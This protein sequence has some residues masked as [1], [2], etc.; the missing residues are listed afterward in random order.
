M[1]RLPASPAEPRHTRGGAGGVGRGQWV[2][3][4]LRVVVDTVSYADAD[5]KIYGKVKA[6][7]RG[8][9][10]EASV[11]RLAE[12][13]GLSVS[14]VEKA[15]TRL[16]RPAPTD[17]IAELTRRQRSHR[18]TGKGLTN[19]RDTR[20]LDADERY[21][22][23][24]VRAADTLRGTLHRLY[25]L[26]R[27]TTFVEHR[28]LTLAEIGEALRH[29]GGKH[30]VGEALHEGTAARLL[31]ELEG[32]GWITQDKRAGYRG[33]HQITV[34]DDPVHLVHDPAT[35][36]PTTATP[37]PS[38]PDAQYGAGPDAQCGAP[39]Y[40]EDHAL[41]HLGNDAPPGGGVRRRRG[42]RKWAPSPVD[43]SAVPATFHA[44]PSPRPYDGPGL[45]LSPRV[46]E[47]LAPVADLLPRINE[48][49]IRTAARAIGRQLDAEVPV[50]DLHDQLL[51]R[52][53]RTGAAN[54]LAD[55][56]R[57][58]LGVAL[59]DW[60]S[61]CG[62]ADCVDGLIRHSG[63]P[64]KACAALPPERHRGRARGHP[65]PTT[66]AST[67]L[68]QCPGCRAPYRPPLRHPNCRLCHHP[69]T[70]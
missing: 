63:I 47:V 19:E 4:P 42:D 35:A 46:W 29:F 24:P 44:E 48:F 17:G 54:L 58:L 15:L 33:R 34:H 67:A 27:Y 22:S 28:D 49:V 37:A 10:C 60:A 70:A 41:T 3:Y 52:R 62:L 25:L 2:R 32:A 61:P 11:A 36:P 26:L 56:G 51:H 5:T 59:A 16:S 50:D 57:W 8:R 7:S 39:A 18:A 53:Q 64:C 20:P 14:A 31:D 1:A 43:N 68:H 12:F 38:T 65:P 69:L 40:K 6:L 55:P 21:V 23:A 9:M 13:T 66:A 30:V 45:S